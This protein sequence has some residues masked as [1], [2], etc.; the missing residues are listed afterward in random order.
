MVKGYP[1]NISGSLYSRTKKLV[2]PKNSRKRRASSMGGR[3][4][5]RVRGSGDYSIL[6]DEGQMIRTPFATTGRDLGN[7]FFGKKGG[8]IGFGLGNYYINK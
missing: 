3:A 4:L 7:Y 5:K 8:D 2:K 6:D 1:V